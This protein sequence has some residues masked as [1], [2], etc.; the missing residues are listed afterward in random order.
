MPRRGR[1]GLDAFDR[2]RRKRAE[3]RRAHEDKYAD[4]RAD[5]VGDRRESEDE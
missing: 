5:R 1:A 3:Q 2:A 4:K